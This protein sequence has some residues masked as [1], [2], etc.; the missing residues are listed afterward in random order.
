[1]TA[2][3]RDGRRSMRAWLRRS[4][5]PSRRSARRHLPD[6]SCRRLPEP[7][8]R[9]HRDRRRRR[10]HDVRGDRRA[11]RTARAAD[12]ALPSRRR[13]D[14][15]LGRRPLQL[16]QYRTRAGQ[17]PVAE[18][19]LLPLGARPLR[20]ARLPRARR[21]A[22]HRAI[23]RRSS[24]SCS[25]TRPRSTS[26]DA[27]HRVR[28]RRRRVAPAVPGRRRDARGRRL[29]RRHAAAVSCARARSSSPRAGSSVP[30]IGATPFGYRLA[31][32]FGLPVVPTR[33]ALVPLAFAPMRSRA[34]ATCPGSRSTSRSAA[35][36]ANSARTCSS[37]TAVCLVRRSCRSR[38]T[39]LPARADP[40]RP[41]AGHRRRAAGSRPRAQG[42]ASRHAAPERLPQ[43]FAQQWCAATA[44][45]RPM[46]ELGER[47]C[48]ESPPISRAGASCP[49]AR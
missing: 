46:K 39:G 47:G 13:E 7:G 27:A 31:E 34:T 11:A 29:A 48:A 4:E 9:R 36:A 20:A 41:A 44:C 18:P 45:A 19:G 23:T 12:R 1:M 15:H 2:S 22:R 3:G 10:R 33:P 14:P 17:L 24:A 5:R 16:H 8:L 49:P 25:A 40:D 26:S 38:R 32:Q 28:P 37:L 35:A 42:P 30:K 21:A 43:R 6:R